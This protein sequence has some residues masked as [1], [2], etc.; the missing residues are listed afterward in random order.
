[1]RAT[2]T[3]LL[4]KGDRVQDLVK[5]ERVGHIDHVWDDDFEKKH[6]WPNFKFYYAVLYDDGLYASVLE[7]RRLR[8]VPER[9]NTEEE[10][11]LESR[12]D[13]EFEKEE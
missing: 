13:K 7:Q 10:E 6:A 1:M 11:E 5:Q 12:I 9:Q 4:K 2:P 8:K 3:P